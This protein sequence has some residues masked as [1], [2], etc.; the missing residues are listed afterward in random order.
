MIICCVNSNFFNV[1]SCWFKG[2]KDTLAF[3]SGITAFSILVAPASALDVAGGEEIFKANCAAC[4]PNGQNVIIYQ[5]TLEK[6]ALETYL[7]GGRNEAAVIK[8][9]TFGKNA[10]PAFGGR[11][12]D[13]A[14]EK[15]AAYVISNS[16]SGWEWTLKSWND[17][18]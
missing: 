8:Q 14:I 13:E 11:L 12:P 18:P 2:R 3:A 9:V 4:H 7:N 6:D 1:F 15:V 5:K 16:E 17:Y 10:M